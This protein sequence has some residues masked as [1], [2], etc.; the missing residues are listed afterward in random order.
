M[1]SKKCKYTSRQKCRVSTFSKVLLWMYL[2]AHIL[3]CQ[4]TAILLARSHIFPPTS[5][6]GKVVVVGIYTAFFESLLIV[7][8]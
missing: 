8:K 4:Q 1:Q 2:G 7:H 6:K 3:C 5:G